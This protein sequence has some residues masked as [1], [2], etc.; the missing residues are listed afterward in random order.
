M[1]TSLDLG[2]GPSPG[3]GVQ[4]CNAAE[5]HMVSLVAASKGRKVAAIRQGHCSVTIAWAGCFSFYLRGMLSPFPCLSV[6]G[7]HLV[8][9]AEVNALQNCLP[10][11]NQQCTGAALYTCALQL[12]CEQ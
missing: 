7:V 1:K 4:Q 9:C 3:K 8:G 11:A 10:K 12:L 6:Q 5:E 2:G